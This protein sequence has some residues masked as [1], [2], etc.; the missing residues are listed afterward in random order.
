MV[1][2]EN[3]IKDHQG[4][5]Q[6]DSRHLTMRLSFSLAL[7]VIIFWAGAEGVRQP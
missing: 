2:L 4:I 6:K 1:I 3:L 7:L 5:R